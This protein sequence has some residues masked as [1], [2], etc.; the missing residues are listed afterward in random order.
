MFRIMDPEM[1]G[2]ASL[3]DDAGD[4]AEDLGSADEDDEAS[5]RAGFADFSR[6]HQIS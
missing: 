4:S 3:D 6:E 5:F 2:A 1:H